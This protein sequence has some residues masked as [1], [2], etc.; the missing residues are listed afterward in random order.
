MPGPPI[1]PSAPV[2]KHPATGGTTPGEVGHD[3]AR[4][5]IP[6]SAHGSPGHADVP[7]MWSAVAQRTHASG[8]QDTKADASHG[9]ALVSEAT[10]YRY[11][12]DLPALLSYAFRVEE[13]ETDLQVFTSSSDLRALTLASDDIERLVQG[14]T[15]YRNTDERYVAGP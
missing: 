5:A 11:F 1:S 13:H 14:I 2:A 8:P 12:P 4:V 15:V 7:P 9:Y 6:P 10:A 3:H